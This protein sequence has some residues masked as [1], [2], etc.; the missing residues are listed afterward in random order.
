[1]TL[2]DK[3]RD[4]LEKFV[5][6]EE[7]KRTRLL[8]SNDISSSAPREDR[9]QDDLH[10]EHGNSDHDN[11]NVVLDEYCWDI[12]SN[13]IVDLLNETNNNYSQQEEEEEEDE[14]EPAEQEQ[15]LDLLLH[16]EIASLIVQ[17]VKKE[18]KL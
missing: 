7:K 5:A 17:I 11:N 13:R 12:E 15:H 2:K 14:E 18:T 3:L 8:I 4:A 1:M 10:D 16:S 6:S 9:D